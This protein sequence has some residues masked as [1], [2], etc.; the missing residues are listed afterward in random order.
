[1]HYSGDTSSK[2]G[3]ANS[4]VWLA[5]ARARPV[6]ETAVHLVVRDNY[7]LVTGVLNMNKNACS[8]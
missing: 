3:P 4:K 6:R 5:I 1:M 8:H 7:V 2:N